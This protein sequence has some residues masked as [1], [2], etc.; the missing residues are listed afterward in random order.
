MTD[1]E[2]LV[3]MIT[4]VILAGGRGRRMGERDKGLVVLNGRPLIEHVIGAI[5]QQNTNILISANQNL[6]RY[7]EYGY[8]VVSDQ[9]SGFQGPLAGMA[10]AMKV[11]TTPYILSMPCDAPFVHPGYQEAMWAGLQGQQTDLVVA[12][13]GQRLQPIHALLPVSLRGELEH[14]LSGP[15]RR[16]DSWYSAHAMGLVDFSDRP[17]MFHNLNT[18]EELER[19]ACGHSS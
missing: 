11:A 9:I 7:S 10:A 1:T 16:V 17:Q 14:F 5:A 8:R 13:D 15:L 3:D 4:P 2:T 19:Y 6:Q 12:Y 18:P